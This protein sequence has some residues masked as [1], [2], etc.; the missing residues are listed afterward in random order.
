MSE[1]SALLSGDVCACRSEYEF[2]DPYTFPSYHTRIQEPYNYYEFGQ[3]YVRNLINFDKSVRTHF[4]A[5]SRP[6]IL[7]SSAPALSQNQQIF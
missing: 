6:R 3:R 5:L 1:L 7:P 4:K 2:R